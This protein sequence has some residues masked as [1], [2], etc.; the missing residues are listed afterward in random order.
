MKVIALVGSLRKDSLNRQLVDT[1]QKR[2]SHLFEVEIA[3]IGILPHYNE[4]DEKTPPEVVQQF[5]QQLADADAVIISTPEYNWSV[6]GVLKNALDW[7]SRVS[8]PLSGKPVLPMGVSQGV[9]G[10]VKAQNHLRQVL[11][12]MG[13]KANTLP[14]AGNEIYIG[15][16]GQ[17]FANGELADEPTL[18]FLD[19]V[20][21]K[22]VLFAKEQ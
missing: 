16:A 20:I 1:I 10:T 14:P 22:F 4:D 2:Y 19:T 21:D 13:V 5:K 18:A 7:T 15:A 6:P 8:H 9:L 17:K 11:S 3:D 12:S